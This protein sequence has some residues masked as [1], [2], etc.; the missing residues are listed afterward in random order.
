[1]LQ[2]FQKCRPFPRNQ[3]VDAG[4]YFAWKRGIRLA[5]ARGVN[6]NAV[7]EHAMS[8]VL[9]LAPVVGVPLP[10]VSYGGTSMMTI[11]ISM[12]L[13]MCVYVHRGQGMRGGRLGMLY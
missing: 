10:L 8:M 7:S 4:K 12:G 13:T 3:A 11:M 1:M 9:G 2:R 5:S 6:S